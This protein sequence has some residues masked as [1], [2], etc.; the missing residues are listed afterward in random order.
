MR[1]L[2]LIDSLDAG[3]AERM[4]VNIANL[5]AK[6]GV[7]SFLCSTVKS[8]ALEQII[9]DNVNF[10]ILGK[11]GKIDV[12]AF[13]RFFHYVKNHDI[14]IIHAHSTSVQLAVL[15]RL[16]YPHIK[17]VWH[18]HYGMSTQM[19]GVSLFKI[20]L[21]SKF[22]SVSIAVSEELLNWST[23]NLS[24]KHIYYL[25]NFPIF[26]TNLIEQ[27]KLYGEFGNRVLLLANLRPIK[28]HIALIDAFIEAWTSFPRWTLHLVG[29]DFG[30]EYG[31]SVR[32]Y[33]V[34]NNLEDSVFVYGSRQDIPY[35]LSQVN[36]GVIASKSEG[37]PLSLLEYGNACL[38]VIVTKV[39]QCE[40]IVGKDG[41]VINDVKTEMPQALKKLFASEGHD[42]KKMGSALKKNI[43][44]HYSAQKF[45]QSLL[46]IYNVLVKAK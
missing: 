10:F 40:E 24:I 14:Q 36:I 16:R 39:G 19:R 44:K 15:T 25:N 35:I 41:I 30:D 1:V 3:G 11:S 21:L 45:M 20:K 2:Q 23:Q 7:T 26:S 4:A 12:K 34:K 28:N 27:T 37:L 31:R 5:N 6:E 42:L 46:P 38:P 9:D 18:N 17:V 33:I 43:D 22:I 8:G 32:E 29:N 13:V